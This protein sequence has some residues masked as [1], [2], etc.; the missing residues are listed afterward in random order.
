MADA[1]AGPAEPDAEPRQALRRKRWSSAFL[2]VGLEQVVIDVLGRELGPDAR[3]L[4]GLEF[5]HHHRA[6]RILRQRL[7][8]RQPDLLPGSSGLRPDGCDQLVC[9]VLA[10][11]LPLLPFSRSIGAR[12]NFL[13]MTLP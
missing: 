1:V 7:I 13:T 6:G 3:R 5:Q 10:H 11:I 4:H 12:T 8:D 9:E 2:K